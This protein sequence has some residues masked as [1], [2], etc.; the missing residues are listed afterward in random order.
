[1]YDRASGACRGGVQG[2]PTRLR[3]S[4][5]PRQRACEKSGVLLATGDTNV[6]DRGKGDGDVANDGILLAVVPYENA[7]E[8]V[9]VTGRHPLGRDAAVIGEIRAGDPGIVVQTSLIGGESIVA[10]LA[11]EQLPRIC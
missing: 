4:R 2:P 9:G 7:E 5:P 1:V 11:G 8:L 10:R 6:V 3:E